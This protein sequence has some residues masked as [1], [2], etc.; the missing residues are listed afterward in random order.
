M[1]RRAT[2]GGHEVLIRGRGAPVVCLPGTMASPL[3]FEPLAELLDAEVVVGP[4]LEWPG[5]HDLDSLAARVARVLDE[6][7]PAVLVG[8]STGGAISLLA[9]SR[10]PHVRGLV[11]SG[12][13]VDMHDHSDVEAVID[14]V[15]TG[16]GRDFWEAMYQRLVHHPLADR[17]AAE[18][19]D[20]PAR[21]DPEAV[22]E[23]LHSQHERDL[24]ECARSIRVPAAIVAGRHDRARGSGDSRKLAHRLGGIGVTTVDA[25]HTPCAEVPA[26]FAT[27]V[28]D[29]LLRASPA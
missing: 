28:R 18:L 17:L 12:T 29:V 3:V 2:R 1:L 22:A 10:S 5:P 8:H 4:W 11:L 14:G 20:Y 19:R 26:V 13:G 16:W 23:V 24:S 25:G 21:L 7:G 6:T 9:A 27:V 15:R